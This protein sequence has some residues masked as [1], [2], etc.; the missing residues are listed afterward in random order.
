MGDMLLV[1][2]RILPL[3]MKTYAI[4]RD[5]DLNRLFRKLFSLP[6]PRELIRVMREAEKD[7]VD[8][9]VRKWYET[10]LKEHHSS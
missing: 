6:D 7:Q 5:T 8:Y 4:A 1:E 2:N 10:R 9:Y 3:G